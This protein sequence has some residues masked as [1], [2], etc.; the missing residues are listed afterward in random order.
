VSQ[1]NIS[2][3]NE[4]GIRTRYQASLRESHRQIKSKFTLR[5]RWGMLLRKLTGRSNRSLRVTNWWNWK[6]DK[7]AMRIVDDWLSAREEDRR[8]RRAQ[9]CVCRYHASLFTCRLETSWNFLRQNMSRRHA[10]TRVPMLFRAR[11]V[12]TKQWFRWVRPL[13]VNRIALSCR[14]SI[15]DTLTII[16][17]VNRV[18]SVP[19]R[20]MAVFLHERKLRGIIN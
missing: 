15:K 14:S 19:V 17:H 3:I 12:I 1:A 16:I 4:A 11:G 5:Y 8:R 13:G 6:L 18:I 10:C 20:I 7:A 2:F 9:R